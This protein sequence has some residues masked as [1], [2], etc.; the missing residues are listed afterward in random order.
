MTVPSVGWK[1]ERC[2]SL[3][4]EELVINLYLSRRG[5]GAGLSRAESS[6][7]SVDGKSWLVSLFI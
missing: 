7:D 5:S 2:K 4:D 6:R 3:N 1:S